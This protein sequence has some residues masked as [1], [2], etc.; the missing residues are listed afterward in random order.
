MKTAHIALKISV[1]HWKHRCWAELGAK[2]ASSQGWEQLPGLRFQAPH[3]TNTLAKLAYFS[4]SWNSHFRSVSTKFL[5]HFGSLRFLQWS[6]CTLV[7]VSQ[8]IIH[9]A[10]LLNPSK[11]QV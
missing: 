1:I 6:P 5:F 10:A 9:T 2:E 3:G 8:T 7:L 11:T 4:A